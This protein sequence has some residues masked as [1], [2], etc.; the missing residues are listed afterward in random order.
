MNGSDQENKEIIIDSNNE[1]KIK[2]VDVKEFETS[3]FRGVFTTAKQNV[4]DII[5]N[6][7]ENTYDAYNN[8]IAFTGERGKGKSSTMI[9]FLQGLKSIKNKNSNDAFFHDFYFDSYKEKAKYNFIT[10]DIIDPSLFRGQES[11]FEIV[12]AKMFSKFKD[13]LDNNRDHFSITD[14]DRREL[15]KHFQNV[16]E[17]LKYTTGNLKDELYKHEALDALIKLSTSS[18][19]RESFQRLIKTYLKVLGKKDDNNKNF[20][21][22]AIDDFDLKIDGVHDMLE[23][24]R[25]FLIS[26]NIIV[27]IACK[28]EQLREAILTSIYGEFLNKLSK[29][30]EIFDRIVD[31][32]ELIGKAEKYISKLIPL[33]RRLILPNIDKIQFDGKVPILDNVP[34]KLMNSIDLY[35]NPDLYNAFYPETLREFHAFNKITSEEFET[36]DKRIEYFQNY[37]IEKILNINTYRNLTELIINSTAKNYIVNFKQILQKIHF[38]LLSPKNSVIKLGNSNFYPEIII[39]YQQL[40]NDIP[41]YENSLLKLVSLYRTYFNLQHYIYSQEN[42]YQY[43]KIY[44]PKTKLLPGFN[45]TNNRR[46]YVVISLTTKP[47]NDFYKFLKSFASFIY[48]YGKEGEFDY[49]GQ[50]IQNSIRH[51]QFSP[52]SGILYHN[53]ELAKYFNVD[54]VLKYYEGFEK[55][56]T[57]KKGLPSS[58]LDQILTLTKTAIDN[59]LVDI[60]NTTIR[61]LILESDFYETLS[62][63]DN[64]VPPVLKAEIDPLINSVKGELGLLEALE[65]SLSKLTKL[66]AEVT[67]HDEDTDIF[68]LINEK[69]RNS[70]RNKVY[71]ALQPIK[72][73]DDSLYRDLIALRNNKNESY[74]NVLEEIFERIHEQIDLLNGQFKE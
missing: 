28:M 4:L 11:L 5:K 53:P 58:S 64:F 40:L 55:S 39:L 46:D 17:N 36:Q 42:R 63:T 67:S 57:K 1:Y 71:S 60:H 3:I 9:S 23:D 59:F 6:Q 43:L 68:G 45:N 33:S 24:V 21:V 18:N 62:N 51:Y 52:I 74:S 54:M 66:I 49:I 30:K 16:F 2:I 25:Q 14:D 65:I 37:L 27:L 10:L 69:E 15:V 7:Q 20:L 13:S 72:E 26:Q 50:E 32:T 22:I 38:D 8:I 19:L 61:K 31:E 73:A 34:Q 41:K 12:L 35:I 29:N 56:D 47:H 44:D 48:S 70:I